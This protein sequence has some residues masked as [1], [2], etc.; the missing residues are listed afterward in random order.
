MKRSTSQS[1]GRSSVVSYEVMAGVG[2]VLVAAVATATGADITVWHCVAG[3]MAGV[4]GA[5][6]FINPEKST[7]S[8]KIIAIL[9]GAGMASLLGPLLAQ[10]AG[11]SWPWIGAVNYYVSAAAG[12][13]VGLFTTPLLR[14]INNP[15]PVIVF[16]LTLLPGV[17]FLFKKKDP[18]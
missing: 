1:G 6:A 10:W 16:V 15:G 7:P 4:F 13:L 9:I 17:G 2:A 3:G 14:T 8:Q 12:L 18:S 5:Y 11:H